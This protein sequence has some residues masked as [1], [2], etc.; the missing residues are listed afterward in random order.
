MRDC[1][2]LAKVSKLQS[3]YTSSSCKWIETSGHLLAPL[4]WWETRLHIR[5]RHGTL[6]WDL[7]RIVERG[8]LPRLSAQSNLQVQM[9]FLSIV[10][11]QVRNVTLKSA[12]A[13]RED[14][15]IGLNLRLSSRVV[16]CQHVARM[17]M[18]D[19]WWLASRSPEA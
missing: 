16:T 3:R 12:G 19:G 17:L 1:S 2:R 5:P 10:G 13:I 11:M 8:C 7:S 18:A 14:R 4:V 9:F 6:R 15:T